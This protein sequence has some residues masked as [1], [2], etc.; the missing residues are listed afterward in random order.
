M[1]AI[2]NMSNKHVDN[3]EAERS[4]RNLWIYG[5]DLSVEGPAVARLK[6][7]IRGLRN[8]TMVDEE[9]P[10]THEHPVATTRQLEEVKGKIMFVLNH[11]AS[12]ALAL[13]MEEAVLAV[14]DGWRETLM[15][16]WLGRGSA[17]TDDGRLAV[18]GQPIRYG[19]GLITT[20]K[21]QWVNHNGSPAVGKTREAPC[22]LKTCRKTHGIASATRLRG[23]GPNAAPNDSA[24][25]RGGKRPWAEVGGTWGDGAHGPGVREQQ[26]EEPLSGWGR[27]RKCR[28]GDIPQHPQEPPSWPR[29]A[30]NRPN[31][32]DRMLTS[33]ND[34][35]HHVREW[36]DQATWGVAEN[37]WRGGVLDDEGRIKYGWGNAANTFGED[38]RWTDY[39]TEVRCGDNPSLTWE[40]YVAALITRDG[41]VFYPNGHK[42]Q[43]WQRG[44]RSQEPQSQTTRLQAGASAANARPNGHACKKALK[45]R[46]HKRMVALTLAKE[47]AGNKA[48]KEEEL[49]KRRQQKVEEDDRRAMAMRWTE[50]RGEAVASVPLLPP[51]LWTHIRQQNQDE[52]AQLTAWVTWANATLL[53]L[54]VVWFRTGGQRNSRW[55]GRLINEKGNI[56][57]RDTDNIAK[58]FAPWCKAILQPG[59]QNEPLNYETGAAPAVF[60]S[61]HQHMLSMMTYLGFDDVIERLQRILRMLAQCVRPGSGL[62]KYIPGPPDSDD[63]EDDWEDDVPEPGPQPPLPQKTFVARTARTAPQ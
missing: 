24:G 38:P 9:A 28:G 18:E 35:L 43:Q 45:L 52:R 46:E 44:Q 8:L 41:R 22:A 2:A 34:L 19:G 58:R 61:V 55:L 53:Q 17:L 10:S 42:E 7:I 23:G 21:P 11:T 54:V 30:D 51:D 50:S 39:I 6:K 4:D 1:S 62:P 13:K 12:K 14:G 29:R 5:Y 20:S 37:S 47:E 16:K 40:Q 26:S 3:I 36:V 57:T 31:G 27:Q 63:E 60:V 49:Q 56:T 59:S 48:R 33:T 25:A 32:W 15:S